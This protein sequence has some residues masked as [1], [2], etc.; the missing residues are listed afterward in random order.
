M[1]LNVSENQV[2]AKDQLKAMCQKLQKNQLETI[3]NYLFNS[4][5]MWKKF[6]YFQSINTINKNNL[7][8]ILFKIK[9]N[10]CFMIMKQNST[11][12]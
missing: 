12:R 3:K 6:K 4:R 5:R 1:S 2:K 9:K 7:E 11:A 8:T 10:I